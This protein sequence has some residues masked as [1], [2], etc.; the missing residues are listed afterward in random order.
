MCIHGDMVVGAHTLVGGPLALTITTGIAIDDSRPHGAIGCNGN[1]RC[2]TAGASNAV[3]AGERFPGK[4]GCR[5]IEPVNTA[6]RADPQHAIRGCGEG[7]YEVRS[8]QIPL[9]GDVHLLLSHQCVKPDVVHVNGRFVVGV[10][11]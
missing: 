5:W 3:F 2:P 10:Q 6:I 8:W 11:R 4:V 7:I 9:Y 1:P